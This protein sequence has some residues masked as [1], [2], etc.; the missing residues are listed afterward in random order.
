MVMLW[1][2]RSWYG[3]VWYGMVWYGMVWYGMVL[4]LLLYCIVLYCIVLYCI[5]IKV[6]LQHKAGGNGDLTSKQ[7]STPKL[8][9]IGLVM[10]WVKS[11]QLLGMYP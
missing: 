3:M 4:L 8:T 2:V 1:V 9:K 11:V 5:V 10:L 6:L 7:S